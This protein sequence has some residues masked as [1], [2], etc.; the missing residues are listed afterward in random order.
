MEEGGLARATELLTE[1][2][3]LRR[4]LGDVAGLAEC[5]EGLAAVHSRSGHHETAVTLVSLASTT[6]GAT[7]ANPSLADS[8]RAGAAAELARRHL[9]TDRFD[10]AVDRGRDIDLD[11]V[12]A[13][14]ERVDGQEAT[15]G[16]DDGAGGPPPYA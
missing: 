8:I 7:G 4:E 10:D 14:C 3:R 1:A 9:P 2:L 11:D 15:A 16:I 6:R 12:L 13:L 5:L